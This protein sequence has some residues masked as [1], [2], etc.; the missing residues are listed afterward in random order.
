VLVRRK[1]H[2]LFHLNGDCLSLVYA[3]DPTYHEIFA[4]VLA[5]L[6]RTLENNYMER[7][8]QDFGYLGRYRCSFYDDVDLMSIGE[9]FVVSN[10]PDPDG[11]VDNAHDR[12]YR[13]ASRTKTSRHPD[14]V[15]L[16]RYRAF[17]EQWT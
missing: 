14:I 11:D 3:Y 6:V 7:Y 15:T 17:Y 12:Y 16:V 2:S 13:R 10:Y 8:V 5:D 1:M 4:R 9:P